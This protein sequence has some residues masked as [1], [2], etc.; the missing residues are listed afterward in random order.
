[1]VSDQLSV[2]R[3]RKIPIVAFTIVSLC[4][5]SVAQDERKWDSDGLCGRVEHVQ[6]IP[7]RKFSNTFSERRRGLR[8]RTL[9]RFERRAGQRCCDGLVPLETTE[10]GSNGR[11]EFKTKKPGDLWLTTNWHAKEYKIAIVSKQQEDSSTRCSKQGIGL[12]DSGNA[13]WW[14]TIT[15]D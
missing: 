11:F 13:D 12:D 5:I 4:R 15:L 7:D 3:F 9:A 6:K 14:V 1:V 10:T 8:G 2:A